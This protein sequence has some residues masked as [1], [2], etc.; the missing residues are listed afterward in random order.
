M[1]SHESGD[2]GDTYLVALQ[3]AAREAAVDLRLVTTVVPEVVDGVAGD[4]PSGAL[5]LWDLYGAADLVTYSSLYEGFG[6]ALV[7]AFFYHVPV[8]INRYS[9][10]IQDIE[11]KGFKTIS[12]DGF[13]TPEVVE[14]VRRVLEDRA[15]RTEMVNH[16]FD[17]A[18]RYY[19]YS[20]LRRRLQTLVINVLGMD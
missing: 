13:V 18:S 11:P 16:N 20:I 8:L 1:I 4:L 19:S 17:L 3:E 6:N 15:L 14:S 10:Y 2:E 12:M 9:I 5:G 7:E